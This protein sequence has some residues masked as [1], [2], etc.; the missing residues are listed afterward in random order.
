MNFRI[1]V[2][3]N[4][5][6]N[7]TILSRGCLKKL[8]N[9]GNSRGGGGGGGR[10]LTSTLWNALEWK[11]QRDGGSKGEVS[12]VGKGGKDIFLNYTF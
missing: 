7:V 9:S 3:R 6:F 1:I 11:L 2:L 10:S 8:E 4:N 12:S 5:M